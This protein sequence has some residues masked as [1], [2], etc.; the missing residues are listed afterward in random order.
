MD[1]LPQDSP[2]SG[3]SFDPNLC[4]NEAEVE[5]KFIVG[6]L[7]PALGYDR[8]SWYQQVA[9][10]GRIRL[11]FLAFAARV[12]P[13]PLGAENL[14]SLVI[15][16]KSPRQ[17][18]DRHEYKLQ[19]KYLASLGVPY[20]VLTNGRELRVYERQ[21]DRAAL[22]FSCGV[23]EVGQRLGE[24][25]SLIGQEQLRQRLGVSPGMAEES[26]S[27]PGIAPP[28]AP[29]SV[30]EIADVSPVSVDA[31]A[32]GAASPDPGVEPGDSGGNPALEPDA[33]VP[34]PQ[35]LVPQSF[36]A[37]SMKVI[38]IYHNK[39][40]VGKTTVST[41][42]AAGLA[43]Q[44][45]RVLLVDIDAQANSTFA[46]GLIKFEFDEESDL[47]DRNISHLLDSNKY[48]FIPELVR[49][50]N[51]FNNREIDVIPSHLSLIERVYE[52][53]Q[54]S[55]S[56]FRLAQKLDLVQDQYDL[57]I[58]DVP[59]ARDI[60]AQT[61]LIAADYLIIPSDMKPFSNQGLPTVK[62]FVKEIAETRKDTLR[63]QP[64]E[65]LGV[66]PSKIL[67]NA[68]YLKGNFV[69]ERKIVEERYELPVFEST[70]YQ[71]SALSACVD[72][73]TTVGDL[74]IPDPQSI[75]LYPKGEESAQEFIIL[76]DEVAD[77]I[78]L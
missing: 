23:A 55:A 25:R 3:D 13:R 77:K 29:D 53:N 57:V 31:F 12:L 22:V 51:G 47:K 41:N 11:D 69:R 68:A 62:N 73:S 64:T 20:G 14:L 36:M 63:K 43:N 59:P 54:K 46:T 60:Y 33:P 72:N 7:L 78:G 52:L 27:S 35:S 8:W 10:G 37:S 61:A 32:A 49:Q 65:I 76:C 39:G 45:Y 48:G 4:R 26:G 30:A 28:V 40:G 75:F 71:R 19:Q 56:C 66:L 24:L 2:F 74:W 42:L 17:N 50:S 67:T 70:I 9:L 34:L 1:D 6:Y 15:E 44:G 21:G 38:A 16:A 58:I 18:L 5:G